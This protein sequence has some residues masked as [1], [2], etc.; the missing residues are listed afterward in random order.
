MS[1]KL[2]L[3]TN[4][5]IANAMPLFDLSD[6]DDELQRI[7]PSTNSSCRRKKRPGATAHDTTAVLP[8]MAPFD[9]NEILSCTNKA[10]KGSLRGDEPPSHSAPS[11]LSKSV[12]LSCHDVELS[13]V[14][15]LATEIASQAS[16][17]HPVP[18][19][20]SSN[21][22]ELHQQSPMVPISASQNTRMEFSVGVPRARRDVDIMYVSVRILSIAVCL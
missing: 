18:G 16:T 21:E 19:E 15:D 1:S 5:V 4:S 12:D 10:V 9:A 13:D 17:S 14:E 22:D 20:M 6:D 11:S 2:K 3:G 7:R 8:I